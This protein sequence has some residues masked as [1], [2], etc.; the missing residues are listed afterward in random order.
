MSQEE[1]RQIREANFH[2]DDVD[3]FVIF[4]NNRNARRKQ[5]G[6]LI[7]WFKEWMDENNLQGKVQLIMHT[8]PK[9]VHGQDLNHIVERLGLNN[10][11]VLFSTQ[12]M[13]L[14]KM[15][16]L[17]NF[18]DVTVNISDAEGFGLATLES[19]SCGVP[20]VVTETGGLQ[21]QVKRGKTNFGVGIKPIS[22]AVIGSQQVPYI[23]ED[24]ISQKRF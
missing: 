20:I 24:R 14:D 21:D 4:W 15:P 22:K 10:R 8:E 3:K 18:A 5:S 17:Y 1:R 13:P 12:K 2:P 16:T 23:Y 19:L 9:D 6:T 7:W 11:E